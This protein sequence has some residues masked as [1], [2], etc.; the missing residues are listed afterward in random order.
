MF[1]ITKEGTEVTLLSFNGAAGGGT[2]FG[3][4]ILDEKG[5]LYGTTQLG[6]ETGDGVGHYGTVFE[7]TTAGKEIILH[8]FGGGTDGGVPAAG[9]LR[10]RAGNL[11]GTASLG[12][13]SN[14][15]EGCGVVFEL[16]P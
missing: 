7:L 10:D 14:C 5:N 13:S 3:G 15:N 9:L 16:T 1:E 2:P 6:G 11:Y 12:G 8:S 4:V